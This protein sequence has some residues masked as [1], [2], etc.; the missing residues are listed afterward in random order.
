MKRLLSPIHPVVFFDV[1]IDGLPQGR[2]GLEVWLIST[3]LLRRF[4]DCTD[5]FA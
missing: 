3:F 4:S 2:I 5:L 1:A